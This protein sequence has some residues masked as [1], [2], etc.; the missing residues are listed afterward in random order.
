MQGPVIGRLAIPRKADGTCSP[1]EVAVN[2]DGPADR[3]EGFVSDMVYSHVDDGSCDMVVDK[4]VLRRLPINKR[5]LKNLPQ[6]T[7]RAGAERYP[8][9]EGES[10]PGKAGGDA[11]PGH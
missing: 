10:A 3:L 4:M 2:L 7:G 8:E 9:P 6:Q 1:F 5:K 11:V